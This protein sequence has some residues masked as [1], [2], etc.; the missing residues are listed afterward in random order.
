M[1][2]RPN[3]GKKTGFVGVLD[4]A[5]SQGNAN[6]EGKD[7]EE[8]KTKAFVPRRHT[9]RKNDLTEEQ[10]NTMSMV[11]VPSM[12]DASGIIRYDVKSL[13]KMRDA[14]TAMPEIEETDCVIGYDKLKEF[15]EE[16]N[17]VIAEKEQVIPPLTEFQ[18]EVPSSVR[19]DSRVRALRNIMNQFTLD[20]P[21]LITDMLYANIED[22][23][24]EPAVLKSAIESIICKVSTDNLYCDAFITILKLVVERMTEKH[25]QLF[26][27]CLLDTCQEHYEE[28]MPEFGEDAEAKSIYLHAREGFFHLLGALFVNELL[29][30]DLILYVIIELSKQYP[31]D[32]FAI[33]CL[34][35]VVRTIGSYMERDTA[36]KLTIDEIFRSL[37]LWQ[38]EKQLPEELI[39]AIRALR[40]LKDAKWVVVVEVDKNMESTISAEWEKSVAGRRNRSKKDDAEEAEAV[41]AANELSLY[42]KNLWLDYVR[43]FVVDD[44][45]EEVAKFDEEQQKVFVHCAIKS[46]L[47]HTEVEQRRVGVLLLKLLEKKEIT[48]ET[49]LGGLEMVLADYAKLRKSNKRALLAFRNMFFPLLLNGEVKVGQIVEL[50]KNKDH[51]DGLLAELVFDLMNSWKNIDRAAAEKAMEEAK[52]TM[53]SVFIGG[54]P[55]MVAERVLQNNHMAEKDGRIVF[56]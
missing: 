1:A 34:L 11:D 36:N 17:N 28:K 2:F 20:N 55:V 29:C 40:D 8:K 39:S 32:P 15:I 27:A 42:C 12:E 24:E 19:V 18:V 38:E 33:K 7:G 54:C 48:V 6:T 5:Y 4:C 16:H 26:R 51:Y 45:A 25:A 14:N 47:N 37:H 44:V 30:E 52:L 9:F 3:Y 43:N 49:L 35:Q 13:L 22:F 46:L 53:D 50:W 41:R 31:E 23:V 10:K 21:E 56:A